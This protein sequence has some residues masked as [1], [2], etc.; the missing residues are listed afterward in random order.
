MLFI[1]GIGHFHPE[2]E[3]SN[4]FLEHLEIGTNQE[5]IMERVG[6]Q[7]RRTVL[8][9][10]Y[11]VET[12]NA[13]PNLS[14]GASVYSNAQTGAKAALKAIERAGLKA[15]DIGMVIGGGCSPQFMIPAEACLVA[16]EL[17]IQAPAFD[18]SSACSSFAAQIH[19]LASMR[20]EALPDYILI[21]NCE[22]NTRTVDY[23]DR[24]TAVLWGDATVATV[25]SAKIPSRMKI[26]QSTLVSDPSG[27]A[28]VRIPSGGHFTQVGAEVQSF[29]I[30]KTVATLE[31][32]HKLSS[33]DL[34]DA[35]FI[36]HQANLRMLNKV[37]EK[38][39]IPLGRH[40]HNIGQFGNCGAAG[41]P[42]VLSQNWDRFSGGDLI[43]VAL[44]G[45]GL[46]WG[47]FIIEVG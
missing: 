40:L 44:V 43:T 1:H 23:R 41:A 36:G 32:L 15:S 30:R 39:K 21:V 4:L 3:I 20:P 46:T 8:S 33:R 27:W 34:S 5:W 31:G 19:F 13:D 18:I 24:N 12:K 29:A 22:N 26:T 2:N 16:A 47:G 10:D 37:C 14:H 6:I 25:V 11:L 45:A 28:K 7:S 35:Y 38:M 9:L 42:S 17:E